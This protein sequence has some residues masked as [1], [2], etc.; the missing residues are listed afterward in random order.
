MCDNR[1]NTM[2]SN[3]ESIKIAGSEANQGANV[4]NEAEQTGVSVCCDATMQNGSS[5]TE[6]TK[7]VSV[8]SDATNKVS[9]TSDATKQVGVTS[10]ATKQVG[11]TSDAT[12][13][14]NVTSDATNKVS[15]TSEATNKVSVTSEATKKFGVISDATKQVGVTSEATNKVGVTS[16][17]TNEVS[18]TSEATKKVGVTSEATKKVNVTS[19]ATKKVG[20]TSEALK[21]VSVTSDAT[22]KVGVTSDATKQVSVTSGATNKVG[23]TSEATKQVGVTSEASKQVGV[24]KEQVNGVKTSQGVANKE[25]C[26]SKVIK[27]SDQQKS[28]SNVGATV[29]KQLFKQLSSEPLVK[30]D[31]LA[32]G[33][34]SGDANNQSGSSKEAV[35]QSG[36]SNTSNKEKAVFGSSGANFNPWRSSNAF[37]DICKPSQ[38]KRNIIARGTEQAL[39]DIEADAKEEKR[40]KMLI[41][42]TG[43]VKY[44]SKSSSRTDY[45]GRLSC[46]SPPNVNQ[47]YRDTLSQSVIMPNI[48]VLNWTN[49]ISSG[50]TNQGVRYN[51]KT[52]CERN[53]SSSGISN[54]GEYSMVNNVGDYAKKSATI[55]ARSPTKRLLKIYLFNKLLILRIQF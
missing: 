24:S 16:E 5:T 38:A 29:S 2:P 41:K 55:S 45:S 20:V 48:H 34:G 13:K 51:S 44:R 37:Y 9:V 31:D 14:V 54:S 15:V 49:K 40:A 18:V 4:S 33:C 50:P 10:D 1:I 23:V 25:G 35:T 3:M 47:Y 46:M 36:A 7:Q 17:A 30:V 26:G 39:L 6:A 42:K 11:V 12:K 43:D 19:E 21:K 22:N 8:T 53:Y 32:A 27:Q 28:V 52:M